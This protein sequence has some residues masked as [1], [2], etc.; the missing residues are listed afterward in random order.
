MELKV[1]GKVRFIARRHASVDWFTIGKEY[2]VKAVAGGDDTSLMVGTVG[3]FG[4]ITVD[5][6]GLD[7]YC[8]SNGECAHGD[9]ELVTD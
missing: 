8:L 9:W 2:P 1:G 7:T 3:R 5:D 6:D 4:F